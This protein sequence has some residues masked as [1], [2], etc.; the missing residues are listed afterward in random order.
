MAD[1]SFLSNPPAGQNIQPT[2]LL[3]MAGQAMTLGNLATMNQMNQMKL[4]EQQQY[5]QILPQLVAS[6]FS[7]E[8]V[9][10]AAQQGPM[11]L[12]Q[13]MQERKVQEL[14]AAQIQEAQ[15]KAIA[16]RA[17][18]FKDSISIL[19]NKANGVVNQQGPL[20]DFQKQDLAGQ[21]QHAAEI[22]GY[23]SSQLPIPSVMA[24]DNQWRQFASGL[25]AAGVTGEQAQNIIAS[26]AKTPAEVAELGARA[27]KEQTE[28]ALAPFVAQTGR[29]S[30]G[31]EAQ[32]AQTGALEQAFG[33]AAVTP[34]LTSGGQTLFQPG[35]VT[36]TPAGMSTPVPG[37]QGQPGPQVVLTPGQEG[38][39]A[40]LADRLKAAGEA[41]A[42]AD[43]V[44]QIV[45]ALLQ[46]NQSG[47]TGPISGSPMGKFVLQSLQGMPGIDTDKIAN[48]RAVDAMSMELVGPIAHMLN[49]RGSNMGIKMTSASKLSSENSLESNMQMGQSLMSDADNVN[50]YNK[51]LNEH[52]QNDPMDLGLT[53]FVSPV[54]GVGKAAGATGSWQSGA[55]LR[56]NPDGS[57][58]YVPR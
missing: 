23:D 9:Q 6:N 26:K 32:K 31:A 50:A 42:L 55:S 4:L 10:A 46:L 35:N 49:S 39:K 11:G 19:A 38:Q 15:G 54:P 33:K 1:F 48:M 41:A 36:G 16:S 2:N 5:A 13:A 53:R 44:K 21:A 14:T 43:R 47:Y 25:A 7:P 58:T 56:T 24:N 40:M 17:G 8:A 34:S 18:A 57:Y 29:I 51:T 22:G 45:P 3:G 12:M 27:G 30:A 52:V 20:T 28:A 37:P